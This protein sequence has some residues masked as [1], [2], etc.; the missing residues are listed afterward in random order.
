MIELWRR[1]IDMIRTWWKSRVPVT[2]WP[3]V[4]GP[5]DAAVAALAVHD[6]VIV[7][8]S[9]TCEAAGVNEI[10]AAPGAL[11]NLVVQRIVLQ[12]ESPYTVQC[13]ISEVAVTKYRWLAQRQGVLDLY[14]ESGCEFRLADVHAL[15]LYLGGPHRFSYT[16]EHWEE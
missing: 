1:F 13:L 9:G 10:V 16:V 5:E 4:K 11:K 3:E 14:W 2:D 8:T 15:N 7:Y 6:P 12:N